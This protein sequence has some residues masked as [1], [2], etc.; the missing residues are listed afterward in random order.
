MGNHRCGPGRALFI[1]SLAAL[2][3]AGPNEAIGQG[4]DDRYCG[5]QNL[6]HWFYCHPPQD[7]AERDPEAS[8]TAQMT[9]EA[10]LE[11][12]EAFRQ[13]LEE[14]RLLAV[15]A[16][17]QENVMTYQQMQWEATVR[18]A[19]FSDQWRRNTWG[20][21]QLDYTVQRPVAQYARHEWLDQRG[22][23]MTEALAHMSDEYGLFYFYRSDC[24]FCQR[25]SP[26]LR[27]F[28]D[29][30]GAE[31]RAISVDGGPMPDFPGARTDAGQFQQLLAGQPAVV[32]AVLL[33]NTQTNEAE[34]ITFGLISGQDL[35]DRIFVTMTREVGEDY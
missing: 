26:V 31:V 23:E 1:A 8:D 25:F 4:E 35:A 16:P 11:S 6:G 15:W 18:A 9:R 12:A 34:W 10:V 5:S 27:A 32:P 19:T 28:A 24:P 22:A 2:A 30:Y 3:A 20:N 33:L 29:H 7:E 17:T 14:Q 21:S 13:R